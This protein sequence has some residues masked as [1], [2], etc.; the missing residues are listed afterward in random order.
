MQVSTKL[1]GKFKRK[2][3]KRSSGSLGGF[4][5]DTRDKS[6]PGDQW[7]IKY[8]LLS[9]LTLWP[10]Q[11]N[12]PPT[13]YLPIRGGPSPHQSGPINLPHE[14]LECDHVAEVAGGGDD[15]PAHVGQPPVLTSGLL[16]MWMPPPLFPLLAAVIVVVINNV[17]NSTSHQRN[18]K[19][20]GISL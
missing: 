4:H 16:I 15:E 1:E 18:A 8:G 13:Y 3:K 11:H 6:T 9:L 2:R 19:T 10:T 5:N 12:P 14:L 7:L 20:R 17:K